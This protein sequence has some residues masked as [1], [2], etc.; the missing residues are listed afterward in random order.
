MKTSSVNANVDPPSVQ[1]ARGCVATNVALPG[2]GSLMAKRAA[3]WPQAALT[4]IGFVLTAIFG[5]RALVWFAHNFSTIYGPDSDPV[6]TLR[7]I[8]F[9]L[10]WA[11]LGIGFF[12]VS[13][14]WSTA[15]NA[16]I[17]HSAKSNAEG[18]KPPVLR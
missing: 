16:A 13:W 15:T 8:W 3:G 17:L 11:L 5:V 9:N 7:A 14:I 12:A 4:V 10:R 1:T 2:F 6:E 18:A